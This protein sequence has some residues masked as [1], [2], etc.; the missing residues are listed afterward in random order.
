M[1]NWKKINVPGS[2]QENPYREEKE[3]MNKSKAGYL[4]G[5]K[6]RTRR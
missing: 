6:R 1:A 2:Q 3:K 5:H 4:S